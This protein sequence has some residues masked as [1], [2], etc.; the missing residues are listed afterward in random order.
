[1]QPYFLPYLGYYSL[2][3]HTD[4]FILFDPVQFIRHGW[5]ERN[6]ILK[7]AEGW[8]YISVPLEKPGRTTLIKDVTVRTTENWRDKIFRQLEHY[9]K[10]PYYKPTIEVL[11]Q[12][13]DTDA[14]SITDLNTQ[15]LTVTCTYL[16][17]STPFEVFSKMNLKIEEVTHAGEW[18]LNICKAMGAKM[19]INPP[20]GRELF[21][22][23]EFEAAGI[24]LY[25]L[26]QNLRPY[27]QR[28][29]VFE[30]GLSIV[31]VMMFND[32]P[33]IKEMLDEIELQ[34]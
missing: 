24:E 23:S 33:A 27:P 21:H 20:G 8:Q 2:I 26:H 25:F 31:D 4:K 28:R 32:V 5:I 6:R 13:F 30:P 29:E 12:A 18:A 3:K 22:R 34:R 11:Q 14:T 1:M 19:Y 7:P 16:Q 10:A 15:V 9:K 17:V